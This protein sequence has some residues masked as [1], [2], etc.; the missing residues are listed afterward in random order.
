METK[1][2]SL[3]GFDGTQEAENMKPIGKNAAV[4]DEGYGLFG[5]VWFSVSSIYF[6]F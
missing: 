2:E 3:H 4:A 1:A 5:C 6:G